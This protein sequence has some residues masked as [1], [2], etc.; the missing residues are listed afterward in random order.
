MSAVSVSKAYR[1][2][3][4][5]T[6]RR[7]VDVIATSERHAITIAQELRDNHCDVFCGDSDDPIDIGNWTTEPLKLGG[8]S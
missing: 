8:P 6:F 4:D 5:E 1:V 2:S 7:Y 3:L